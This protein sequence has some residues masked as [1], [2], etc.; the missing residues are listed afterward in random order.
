MSP[1]RLIF[2]LTVATAFVLALASISSAFLQPWPRNVL[3]GNGYK[4]TNHYSSQW[5]AHHLTG[6]VAGVGD[7]PGLH[8]SI[9]Q[10]WID[11][12][13]EGF[14]GVGPYASCQ[15]INLYEKINTSYSYTQRL[16][17]TAAHW[18]WIYTKAY[19]DSCGVNPDSALVHCGDDTLNITVAD[20]TRGWGSGLTSIQNWYVYQYINGAPNA[21]PAQ[22]RGF[23]WLAN[24][25]RNVRGRL[26]I[27]SAYLKHFIIDSAAA[28]GP[29]IGVR[30]PRCYFM[31]NQYRDGAR[32]GSYSTINYTDGGPTTSQDWLEQAGIGIAESSYVYHDSSTMLIDTTI[33]HVLD[34]ATNA[35]GLPRI[36]G[37]ANCT[38]AN[39]T[40]FSKTLKYTH[41]S[42]ENLIGPTEN[43]SR[44]EQWRQYADTLHVHPNRYCLWGIPADLIYLDVSGNLKTDWTGTGDG[45]HRIYVANLSF[46]YCVQD[47]NSMINIMRFNDTTRWHDISEV[48]LGAPDS[49]L[50]TIDTLGNITY[51]RAVETY[52]NDS[53]FLWVWRRYYDDSNNVVLFM[54]S[55][56]G[57]LGAHTINNVD[58]SLLVSLGGNYYPIDVNGDTA[59]STVSQL[60]LKPYMGFIGTQALPTGGTPTISATPASFLFNATI[61]GPNPSSQVLTVKNTGT[62]TLNWTATKSQ[63]WLT[64]SAGSG[65]DSVAVTLSASISGKPVGIFV[66]TVVVSDPAA[67]N[68]PQKRV[69]TLKID[70]DASSKH[71]RRMKQ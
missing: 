57:R 23:T 35:H 33:A 2:R 13:A 53:T 49:A 62:G 37:F 47:T 9:A 25:M 1:G 31:D 6:F 3:G 40:H 5:L 22:P 61:G 8:D 20:G 56:S 52:P 17:D 64:L 32:L 70:G 30:M 50:T 15:E 59:G 38:K 54:S 29:G 10:I 18:L 71:A 43:P 11:S 36:I 34:S 68:T 51:V 26:A 19:Y 41:V 58:E 66:D 28:Y 21:D 44:W 27:A 55:S 63:S 14:P 60:Y 4:G 7:W 45:P 16:A 46:Y 24:G 65:V 12:G 69:V 39:I 42:L 48:V 67:T